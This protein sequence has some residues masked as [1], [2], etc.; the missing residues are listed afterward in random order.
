ML[1]KDIESK[2][3]AWAKKKNFLA[4]KVRFQDAGY[5][6]RLFIS[7]SGHTIFIE[8]KRPGEKPD[9]LQRYR[10]RT[11][12]QRSIPAYWTDNYVEAVRILERALEPETVPAPSHKA[13]VVTGIRRA[14]TGSRFGQDL[15]LSRRAEDLKR[16]EDDPE[17]PDYSSVESDL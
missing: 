11:L 1:E 5:P 2:V 6:D 9:P 10:I 17:G 12:Q 3:V 7:P 13:P 15:H 4:I 14:I 16:K 8:F